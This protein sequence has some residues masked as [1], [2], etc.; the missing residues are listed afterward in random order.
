M[1]IGDRVKCIRSS[2]ES[3]YS[4]GTI[5][6]VEGLAGIAMLLR[7]NLGE[8]DTV[9]IPMNG[10][11]W[12]FEPVDQEAQIAALNELLSMSQKD[13]EE[14]RVMTREQALDSLNK[15]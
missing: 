5:Y 1:K 11:I 10:A 6:E 3:L 12:G 13:F 15:A 14:G 9:P 7:D 4:V 8:L 2:S